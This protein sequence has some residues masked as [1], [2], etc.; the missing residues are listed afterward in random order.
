MQVRLL[1]IKHPNTEAYTNSSIWPVLQHFQN[2]RAMP[3]D[4]ELHPS[5][6]G[7]RFP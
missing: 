2:N 1:N 4:Q 6:R 5:Y 7:R 3:V